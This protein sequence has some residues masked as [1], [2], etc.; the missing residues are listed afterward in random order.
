MADKFP[1]C[2]KGKAEARV[3]GR[4]SIW[5]MRYGNFLKMTPQAPPSPFSV[6]PCSIC[7]W[8]QAAF[9]YLPHQLK[10]KAENS[11]QRTQEAVATENKNARTPAL[12]AAGK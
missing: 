6:L 11:P 4:D 3:G 9:S 2:F 5:I 8:K 12:A 10:T 7:A 1:P